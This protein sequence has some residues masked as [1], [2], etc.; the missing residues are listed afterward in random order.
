V[1]IVYH[2]AVVARGDATHLLEIGARALS[3]VITVDEDEVARA[4]A[5]AHCSVCPRPERRT[6]VARD[7]LE[8]LAKARSESRGDGVAVLEDHPVEDVSLQPWIREEHCR[9]GVT[10]VHAYLRAARRQPQVGK[11]A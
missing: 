1:E 6:R 5:T 10:A 2:E 8:P 4:V 7:Q 3:I 9:N 11:S